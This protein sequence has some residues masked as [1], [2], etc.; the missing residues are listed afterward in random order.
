M[1]RLKIKKAHIQLSDCL[2]AY[3]VDLRTRASLHDS[4]IDPGLTRQSFLIRPLHQRLRECGPGILGSPSLQTIMYPPLYTR[5]GLGFVCPVQSDVCDIGLL[6]SSTHTHSCVPR[7]MAASTGSRLCLLIHGLYLVFHP[8]A[9]LPWP[10]SSLD[11]D[12]LFHLDAVHRDTCMHGWQISAAFP[13][14]RVLRHFCT[15]TSIIAP[16]LPLLY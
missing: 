11:A 1:P 7:H 8:P 4:S 2:V 16:S 6:Q 9:R 15:P 5:Q 10:V 12:F 3:L 13:P 14:H